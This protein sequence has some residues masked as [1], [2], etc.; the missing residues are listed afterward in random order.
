MHPLEEF[1]FP[2]FLEGI[3]CPGVWVRFSTRTSSRCTTTASNAAAQLQRLLRSSAAAARR[4]SYC[5]WLRTLPSPT[6]CDTAYCCTPT[7]LPHPSG[8]AY[9][10]TTHQMRAA[11]PQEPSRTCR[12]GCSIPPRLVDGQARVHGARSRPT[13][14]LQ[15]AADI[16]TRALAYET[17]AA[18]ASVGRDVCDRV[19]GQPSL[20]GVYWPIRLM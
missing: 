19:G 13:Q 10:I 7:T 12:R 14:R 9:A 8:N 17:A 18:H 6:R 2:P 3:P 15:K 20:L 1:P 5:R 11:A 16:S 4:A